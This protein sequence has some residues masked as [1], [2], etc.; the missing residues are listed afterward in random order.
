MAIRRRLRRANEKRLLK[1]TL[2]VPIAVVLE[3]GT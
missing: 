1:A 3:S 2:G